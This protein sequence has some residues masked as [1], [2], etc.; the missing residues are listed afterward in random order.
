MPMI[1]ECIVTTLN[2]E[3]RVHIAPLGLIA[4]EGEK[5]M[6][7]LVIYNDKGQPETV[8]YQALAPLLLNELLRKH[9]LGKAGTRAGFP[10]GHC[11]RSP[12]RRHMRHCAAISRSGWG[13]CRCQAAFPPCSGYWR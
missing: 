4:E 7:E 5:V 1:R 8:A 11:R 9:W 12:T 2:E 6:P 13:Q 3:G 10:C